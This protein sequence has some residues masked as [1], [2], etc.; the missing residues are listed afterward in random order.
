M[1]LGLR[2]KVVI[3]TGAGGGIGRAISQTLAD[4]GAIPVIA[5]RRPPDPEVLE[6][7]SPLSPALGWV[8]LDLSDDKQCEAA[9]LEIKRRWGR[10]DALVNNAGSMIASDWTRAPRHFERPSTQ[11][12]STITPSCISNGLN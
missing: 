2:D 5:D 8:Q 11:T 3:V 7:L 1:E 6:A 4:E 10:I 12:S 9:V